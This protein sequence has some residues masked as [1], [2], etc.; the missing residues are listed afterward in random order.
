M[1]AQRVNVH[2]VDGTTSEVVLTQWSM[3]QFAQ[4]GQTK[5]WNVDLSNPGLLG[6]VMLRYQ[7]YCEIHRDPNKPRPSF[8]KWDMTVQEVE[9][10]TDAEPVDPTGTAPSGD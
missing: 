3:G 5:G 2:Y 7:V 10:I 6:L 8:D 1:Y 4:Y 9:P